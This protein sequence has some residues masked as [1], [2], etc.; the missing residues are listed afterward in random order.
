[1]TQLLRKF[2]KPNVN[3]PDDYPYISRY[4]QFISS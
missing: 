2:V 4:D 1:V 3:S